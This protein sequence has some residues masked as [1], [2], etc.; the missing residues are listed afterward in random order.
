MTGRVGFLQTTTTL[1]CLREIEMA[2]LKPCPFCGGKA[3]VTQTGRY[4][5]IN[6]SI[7]LAFSIGCP[8]CGASVPNAVG[9]ISINID[10][11]GNLNCW[12]DDREKAIAAWNRRSWKDG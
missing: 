9:D 5:T 12:L 10:K 2:E 7:K 6:Q 3:I 11:N 1:N 8:M 4:L